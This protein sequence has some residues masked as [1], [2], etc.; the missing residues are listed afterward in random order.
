[1]K[2][3]NSVKLI[4]IILICFFLI[5]GIALLACP[6]LYDKSLDNTIARTNDFTIQIYTR[7]YKDGDVTEYTAWNG[8]AS[9]AP[10]N[11]GNVFSIYWYENE[12]STAKNF[13]SDY[14]ANGGKRGNSSSA[15]NISTFYMR[16]TYGGIG[17]RR[18][19]RIYINHNPEVKAGESVYVGARFNDINADSSR[20]NSTSFYRYEDRKSHTQMFTTSPPS[21]WQ[22]GEQMS[23]TVYI[24]YRYCY[25]LKFNG[26]GNSGGT[27]PSDMTYLSG[28]DFYMPS[29]N[30]ERAGYTFKGWA[31][32]SNATEAEFS[33]GSRYSDGNEALRGSPTTTLY[34]VWQPNTYRVTAYANNGEISETRGWSGSGNSAYKD[35]VYKTT[36]GTMPSATR[37]GYYL[38][39]WYT[40]ST[41]GSQ[42]TDYNV[43]DITNNLDVYAHWTPYDYTITAFANG[44]VIPSTSG[45]S[46]SGVSVSKN[47]NFDN[48]YGTLP[49]PTRTGYTFAGWYTSSSGGTKVTSSTI[50]STTGNKSIH[51]HWTVNSYR[52]TA[53]LGGG[54][55]EAYG[56][57]N[58]NNGIVSKAINY[59]STYGTLPTV[60]RSGY[61]FTGWYTAPSG[62]SKVESTTVMAT[63]S[64]ST[65]YAR[66]SQ[67]IY[68]VVLNY[69][70]GTYSG[71]GSRSEDFTYGTSKTFPV[72]IKTGYDLTMWNCSFSTS[73]SF[74][75]DSNGNLTI[76]VPYL[77]E[78]NN[79]VT[80]T[81]QWQ[82]K[83]Y[84]LTAN[85]NG[86][87]IPTTSGWSG[88]GASAS[89]TITF[90]S[91]YGTLPTPTRTGHTF[92]GWYTAASS[93]EAVSATTGVTTTGNRTIYAHWT[94]NSYT[95][96]A[97]A[98]MTGATFTSVPNGWS[99][100]GTTRTRS[101]IYNTSYGILPTPA[102]EGYIFL[103]WYTAAN[104]GSSV[105]STTTMG[106]G[107]T[108][109]YAHWE[110]TWA[111]DAV[112]IDLSGLGGSGTTSDPYVIDS[113]TDIA[114]LALQTSKNVTFDGKYFKQTTNI[115][116]EGKTWLP[117]GN[118]TT[119]FQ[120]SYDG[121]GYLIT[122]I[123][124]IANGQ[125]NYSNV[126]LFGYTRNATIKNVNI[127]SGTIQGYDYVG[128]IVG[129]LNNGSI[130]NCR[131][132]AT[133]TGHNY[134]GMI[135]YGISTSILSSYNYGSVSGND[136]V[137]GI[138]GRNGGTGT[139]LE[140]CYMKGSVTATASEANCGGILG[141]TTSGITL[142]SCGF[143][144]SVT[145]GSNTGLLTGNLN[146]GSVIDCF[147][148]STT[149]YAFTKGSGI[150]KSSLYIQNK[151]SNN[152]VKK[153]VTNNSE[154]NPFANWTVAVNNQPLPKGFSWISSSGSNL[155]MEKL[156]KLGYTA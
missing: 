140:N 87:S 151:A 81:A 92:A 145:G 79:S 113:A 89:K 142:Q 129:N 62:G 6:N 74:N 45:W 3:K 109:I 1:M 155:T 104:G 91:T 80:F 103:G 13:G 97:D 78:N 27:V 56:S 44:G 69:N 2:I 4:Y 67:N 15:T 128:S 105:Y 112:G 120:G 75:C 70:G 138:L 14:Y 12:G 20:S 108:R 29:S 116:L 101:V 82:A 150:V 133:V 141:Q 146:G 33:P 143:I 71:S 55:V 32:N 121:N 41:G 122:N 18:H 46:G 10:V 35:V 100:S 48:S 118:A 114:F 7:Y 123:T 52:V 30:L 8:G 152:P 47:V 130:E 17:V 86:G 34:A 119:A 96:T 83:T 49:T 127:I 22:S 126:G 58:G 42:I 153:Y 98:N 147:A 51:A 139:R 90:D 19:G 144:G 85:A 23:G 5:G 132:G 95:L 111:A 66:W 64:A 124:T 24:S 61:Y 94:V 77:G 134:V 149:D 72:P 76:T 50:L 88:S 9:T 21:G 37:Y 115:D 65:I 31:R 106:A 136:Y 11:N 60:K 59:N 28:V 38:T 148:N 93:G 137:G 25:G 26:N 99:G 135:G 73:E 102:K 125:L 53:N 54:Y 84:T 131:S 57:F 39:G 43:V 110:R 63:A 36:Y 68:K 154:T 107:N 40:S 16:Y 156:E 117:I